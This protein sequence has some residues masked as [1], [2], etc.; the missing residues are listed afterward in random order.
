MKDKH[1]QLRF[2]LLPIFAW[3]PLPTLQNLS[4][5]QS[6]SVLMEEG[7]NTLFQQ[8]RMHSI[9]MHLNFVASR[10]HKEDTAFFSTGFSSG[11]QVPHTYKRRL[12][13]V[14]N[15]LCQRTFSSGE[16]DERLMR[17]MHFL[18]KNKKHTAT[19]CSAI[20]Q[21]LPGRTTKII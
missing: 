10:L 2:S 19:S 3:D 9:D 5:G 6:F 21:T 14:W 16:R 4:R 7:R 8:S 11:S 17:L 1:M 12:V 13:I 18:K 20:M 15:Q